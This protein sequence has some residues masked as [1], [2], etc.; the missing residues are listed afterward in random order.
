MSRCKACGATFRRGKIRSILSPSG[1]LQSAIVCPS[2]AGRCLKIVTAAAPPPPV[3]PIIESPFEA[4][5]KVRAF[6]EGR[7][8]GLEVGLALVQAALRDNRPL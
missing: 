7:Q 1:E 8:E 5:E 4:D 6:A 3:A 2:C